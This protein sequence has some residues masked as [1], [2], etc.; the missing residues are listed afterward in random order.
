MKVTA[1]RSDNIQVI[2]LNMY[3]EWA[4]TFLTILMKYCEN[5]GNCS[6]MKPFV[7]YKERLPNSYT[8]LNI[9]ALGYLA[10]ISLIVQSVPYS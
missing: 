1:F 7:Q 10:G 6:D 3:K 8:V 2:H 5:S 9:S 4:E